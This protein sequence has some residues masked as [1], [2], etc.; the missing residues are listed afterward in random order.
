MPISDKF[1]DVA[2]KVYQR[3]IDE[4][5]KV[6][7]DERAEKIGY[8]IREAQTQKIPYMF[9]IGAKEFET[10]T[11]SIRKRGEGEVGTLSIDDAIS[12]IKKEINDKWL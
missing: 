11:V 10:N 7:I 1:I 2:K 4:C 5:F 6:E 12:K 9:I 8:K 3:L